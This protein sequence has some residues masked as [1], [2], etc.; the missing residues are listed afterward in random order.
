MSTLDLKKKL[1]NSSSFVTNY[2]DRRWIR[3]VDKKAF[4]FPLFYVTMSRRAN[5]EAIQT[6]RRELQ[7]AL[8]LHS[9]CLVSTYT[10]FTCIFKVAKLY[11][12]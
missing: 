12:F 10:V 6:S 1:K 2:W 9:I 3:N 7:C 11:S 5:C 4:R 8:I